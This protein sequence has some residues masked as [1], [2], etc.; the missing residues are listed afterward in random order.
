MV[1]YYAV[2]NN[3]LAIVEMILA[4]NHGEYQPNNQSILVR[5]ITSIL[6]RRGEC[7][8]NMLATLS[9]YWFKIMIIVL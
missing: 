4:H 6:R 5:K 9:S 1:L 8:K 7:I 2:E 3:N